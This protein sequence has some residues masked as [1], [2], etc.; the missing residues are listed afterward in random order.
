MVMTVPQDSLQYVVESWSISYFP[1]VDPAGSEEHGSRVTES[2]GN[3]GL[4]T[5]QLVVFAGH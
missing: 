2:G 5:K 3:E 4:A 1:E